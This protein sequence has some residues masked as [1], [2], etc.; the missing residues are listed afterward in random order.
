M[1]APTSSRNPVNVWH[2][3]CAVI[4]LFAHACLA[5]IRE[6][7]DCDT[8]PVMV[9]IPAGNFMM[10]TADSEL[11]L[12]PR[13]GK[14]NS[15]EAPQHKVTFARPFA[16]S[17]YE[18]TVE[19]FTAFVT[20]TGYES[21]GGC[22]KLDSE[23][24]KITVDKS[25]KW[26]S[27]GFKQ[28]NDE[29][30]VCVSY[31]DAASYAKWL[32]GK[33]GK[34]YHVPTEAQWEYAT[35]AGSTTRFFWGEAAEDGC[36]YANVK[37]IATSIGTDG[38][39]GEQICDDGSEGIAVVGS[40][41]PNGFG[42]HDLLGN[43]WE[44]VS[45]CSHPDYTGAPDDGTAWLDEEPCLFRIIRGGS[46]SNPVTRSG[47]AIRAGRPVSGMAPNLGFRV[48]SSD[49]VSIKEKPPPR[50][51]ATVTTQIAD[52]LKNSPG[53]AL[54]EKHCAAC[55]QDIASFTGSYG[56]DLESIENTIR[57]G[58]NNTMSMPNFGQALDEEE[59]RALALYIRAALNW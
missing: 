32:T 13:S 2:F 51:S 40:Y 53:A 45:D 18:I 29:P 6:Y 57:D 11:T 56:T 17:K 4:V 26:N 21:A 49:Y 46:Y 30:V 3:C 19:Q 34:N 31:E 22:L 28:R 14:L 25:A 42:I 35:R 9:D 8:C 41:K 37:P 1:T 15:N 59:I 27:P 44:W 7:T 55:H 12:N 36:T 47:S 20:D 23:T 5:D 50:P 39:S 33:T 54:F 16:I 48:A 58:G 43:V 38:N 10:G 24:L 52:E